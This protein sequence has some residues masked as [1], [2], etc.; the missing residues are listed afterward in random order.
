[1]NYQC[2]ITRKSKLRSMR[3]QV[4]FGNQILVTAP[5]WISDKEIYSFIDARSDWI[6]QRH[7]RQ[8]VYGDNPHLAIRSREHYLQHRE[9]ARE[10]VTQK[11]QQWNTHYQFDYNRISIK[12][13]S[14]RWGS[15]SSKRNLNFHY[16]LLF[17]PEDV[18]D[19]V[20]VHELC[21]LQEMNHGRQFWAL[22]AETIPD[23]KKYQ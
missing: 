9:A 11:V 21:H 7:E 6:A 8:K 1:M 23:Y 4:G 3:M 16:K 19:Y 18:L 12:N 14:T 22:V 5:K 13:M 10:L 20:V 17:V 15:C 2:T